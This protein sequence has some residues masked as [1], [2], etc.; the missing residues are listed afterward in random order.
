MDA[1]T[2]AIISRRMPNV[3]DLKKAKRILITGDSGR[4][5]TNLSKVLSQKLKLKLYSTDDFFWKIKFTQKEDKE[6]SLK[7]ISKVYNQ[8]EWII[9]GSTRSLVKEGLAK[10]DAIIH[11]VY[12]N[13]L[14]QFWT[15]FK[16]SLTR[17]GEKFI[18]LFSLYKHLIFKKYGFGSEKGKTGIA[19]MLKPYEKKV[20]I[21][22]SFKE[23]DELTKKL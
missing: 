3:D 9:E 23:I 22:Y 15:L 17:K 14:S 18:D 20:I 2:F 5:K 6:T 13:L 21:L 4:G 7:K 1:R 8:N 12:P 19:D 10:A 11:L 16:R